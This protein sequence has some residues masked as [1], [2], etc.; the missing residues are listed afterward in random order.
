[1]VSSNQA[2]LLV[3]HVSIEKGTKTFPTLFIS[4]PEGWVL[5]PGWS[6][7]RDLDQLPSNNTPRQVPYLR[8]WSVV[9]DL[10]AHIG[11]KRILWWLLTTTPMKL[12]CSCKL[13]SCCK[14]SVVCQQSLEEESLESKP[15][16][17]RVFFLLRNMVRFFCHLTGTTQFKTERRRSSFLD[18]HK[19]IA[20]S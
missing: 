16:Y 18:S 19:T 13:H 20:S 17:T 12:L 14:I 15:R 3:L 1:M 7:Y 9:R 4:G 6:T 5:Y 10:L 8:M 2:L 11:A